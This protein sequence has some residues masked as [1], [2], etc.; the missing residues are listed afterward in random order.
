MVRVR[1]RRVTHYGNRPRPYTTTAAR[2]RRP[3]HLPPEP[4]NVFA[5]WLED[6][7]EPVAAA[8]LRQ[9]F[10]LVPKEGPAERR[11]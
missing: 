8:K 2:L 11:I 7:G 6:N 4:G 10:P 9:A 1:R 5:D 3:P